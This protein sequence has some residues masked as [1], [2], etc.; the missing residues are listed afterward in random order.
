MIASDGLWDWL[1]N[2]DVANIIVDNP[3]KNVA[4]LLVRIAK[5]RW[6]ENQLLSDD[7]TC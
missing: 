2:K 6:N 4:E 5:E 1:T 7:I 3:R